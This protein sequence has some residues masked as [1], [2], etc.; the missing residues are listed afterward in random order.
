MPAFSRIIPNRQCPLNAFTAEPQLAN[1]TLPVWR[2][3]QAS[4]ITSELPVTRA[5]PLFGLQLRP[6]PKH[7]II[8][9]AGTSRSV[10]VPFPQRRPRS[11]RSR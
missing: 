8:C 7:S 5:E 4:G 6:A 1:A 2:P 9:F 3:Y 10:R 11:S